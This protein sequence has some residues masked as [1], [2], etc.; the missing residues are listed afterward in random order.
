MGF[1]TTP[2]IVLGLSGADAGIW[3]EGE[4]AFPELADK[5][6]KSQ[7]WFD[8]P[9]LIYS[10]DGK[11]HRN[12]PMDLPLDSLPIMSRRWVDNRRY[13][14]EGGQAGIETKRGCYC[15]CIYC[16]D[17]VAKG[18][19]VR[20]KPPK[21]VVD[22]LENLVKQ[23]IDH[24]HT[25]DS[26]FNVPYWHALQVCEEIIRRRLNNKIRWYAYCSPAEFSLEIAKQMH[27]AGCV[28]INFGVDSGDDMMLKHL[29]R[30]FS[31]HKIINSARWCKDVGIATMF[32][33]LI[34][35]PGET[36]ES[37]IRTIELMKMAE[38]DR[39]GISIG[40]RIYPG[41]EL[42]RMSKNKELSKGLI[43]SDDPA[44][45]LFFIEPDI[46]SFVFALLDELI[47]ND[48]RFFFFDP[49]KPN[50]NYNY[51]ANQLLVDAI[52]EGYRGAYWDI[53][54]RLSENS[55]EK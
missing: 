37:I 52:K 32:D 49:S 23:G 15:T 34:G 19:K 12:Q 35:S 9:N 42:E 21:S 5:I 54:R 36:E 31:T 3:G 7:R 13:F 28:G 17:P 40:V 48:E 16:A 46:S 2:E 6:E 20:V 55:S 24:I 53:L 1:S 4:F 33:L 25:C 38:P 50:R 51:N 29:K 10:V 30:N 47:D 41:T 43:G 11:C 14:T 45:P 18:K 44:E 26:E 8:L 39:I 22:E 27:K